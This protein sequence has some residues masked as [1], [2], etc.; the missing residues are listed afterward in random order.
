MAFIRKNSFIIFLL[1]FVLVLSFGNILSHKSTQ[2]NVSYVDIEEGDTLWSLAASYSGNVPHLE[3]IEE[4]MD[5]NGLDTH[6]LAVGQ[7]IAIPSDQ[8]KFAPDE[9]IKLA[10]DSE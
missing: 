4:V 8:L 5:A 7:S 1:S 10:G 3:W 2:T 9:T 6:T